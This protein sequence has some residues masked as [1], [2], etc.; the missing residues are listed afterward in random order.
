MPTTLQAASAAPLRT[1]RGEQDSALPHAVPAVSATALSFAYVQD[2][3]VLD[4]ISFTLPQGTLM[5]LIGP[6]GGGK[7]TLLRLIL[8]LLHPAAG[9]LQIFGALPVRMSASIGYV[10]QFSTLQCN[11]PATTLDMV[12]MGAA[13][14]GMRGGS[15]PTDVQAKDK[16]MGYLAV[17]GLEGCAK[18]PVG[19]LSGGQRQ[20]AL[21]V[22][23]LM[24]APGD[25]C[26]PASPAACAPFLLLLDEPTASVDPE[27]K[28]CFY[29][30]LGKL[31]GRV[32]MLV[33]SHDLFLASPFFDSV[34]FVNKKLTAVDASLT[35]EVVRS[36]YGSHLHD[37][38]VA[39]MQHADGHTHGQG[40][41]HPACNSPPETTRNTAQEAMPPKDCAFDHGFCEQA[42]AQA[43][44]G[45][46]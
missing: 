33:V 18:Q 1:I 32:S 19:S 39:D 10:P 30:F 24:S 31:R 43:L 27:G 41:S 5:A 2:E 17:L 34:L 35:P 16:A 46:L 9:N 4:D 22:R 36:L 29:E 20:R 12:L 7:T 44:K 21:V 14:P 40:C 28:F 25:F 26:N 23:A 42:S 6:N 38:P 45:R 3:T 15:W 11:F 37:C 13:R 8:G